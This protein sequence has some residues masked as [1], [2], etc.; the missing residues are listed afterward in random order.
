MHILCKPLVHRQDGI[1]LI[2]ISIIEPFGRQLLIRESV[3]HH[4]GWGGCRACS[5]L[6]TIASPAANRGQ[7]SKNHPTMELI[8]NSSASQTNATGCSGMTQLHLRGC[9][10]G[11]GE[12]SS[13]PAHSFPTA[14]QTEH[15]NQIAL[16][17]PQK[18]SSWHS[19]DQSREWLPSLIQLLTGPLLS[20]SSSPR[21][22]AAPGAAICHN[23][24]GKM[25][26]QEQSGD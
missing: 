2:R 1:D 22:G 26:Q 15:I 23:K 11:K 18:S 12:M 19:G 20:S 13:H 9:S 5:D 6:N 7:V 10:S 4:R 3:K 24:P 21:F 14:Q 17:S 8:I 16:L 25:K